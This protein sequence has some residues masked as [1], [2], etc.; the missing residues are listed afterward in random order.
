MKSEDKVCTLDQAKRLVELG[1]VLETEKTW[2]TYNIPNILVT[3]SFN[4]HTIKDNPDLFFP[5]PDVAELGELLKNANDNL[6]F[7][8]GN[9][10]QQWK[11]LLYK[12]RT[13]ERCF[14]GNTEAQARC[15]ALIWLLENG[16]IKPNE[17]S[18]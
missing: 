1:V 5:A 16:Y 17:L 7:Y 13:Y 3:T 6:T 15:A 4:P 9:L 18:K 14:Y 8:E 2:N 10:S 11:I 12:W